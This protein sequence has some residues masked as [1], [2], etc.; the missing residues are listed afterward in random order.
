MLAYRSVAQRSEEPTPVPDGDWWSGRSAGGGAFGELH[1]S[2][3]FCLRRMGTDAVKRNDR[4]R[5]SSFD[6]FLAGCPGTRKPD[7]SRR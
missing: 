3:S 6:R 7:D 4:P 5:A 1:L 2:T